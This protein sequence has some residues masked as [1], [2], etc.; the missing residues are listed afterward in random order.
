MIRVLARRLGQLDGEEFE[1]LCYRM[2]LFDEDE[3]A[4]AP[5]HHGGE[6]H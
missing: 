3:H 6:H 4:R 2:K 1:E 5:K